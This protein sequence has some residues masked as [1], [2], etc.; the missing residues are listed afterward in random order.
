MITVQTQRS[1]VSAPLILNAKA[2]WFLFK[3]FEINIVFRQNSMRQSTRQPLLSFG[4]QGESVYANNLFLIALVPRSTTR[5]SV[6]VGHEYGA[7]SE[8]IAAEQTTSIDVN[9]WTRVKI[10]RFISNTTDQRYEVYVN[11][12]LALNAGMS[13]FNVPT[14]FTNPQIYGN[15]KLIF[16]GGYFDNDVYL[17][18]DDVTIGFTQIKNELGNAVFTDGRDPGDGIPSYDGVFPIDMLDRPQPRAFRKSPGASIDSILY[19]KPRTTWTTARGMIFDDKDISGFK[20]PLPKLGILDYDPLKITGK[21]KPRGGVIEDPF[22]KTFVRGNQRGNAYILDMTGSGSDSGESSK[23]IISPRAF[24][25]E[26]PW[27]KANPTSFNN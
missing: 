10:V 26:S 16:G 21:V 13:K 14:E 12:V 5:A 6:Y 17:M 2:E 11:G 4:F 15:Q 22:Y 19:A 27:K 25:L 1:P 23:D 7:G 20:R 8:Q 3:D 9:K 18:N 24:P